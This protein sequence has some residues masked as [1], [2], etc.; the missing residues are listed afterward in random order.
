MVVHLS[1]EQSE[2]HPKEQF[3]QIHIDV[4]RN[5]TDDFNLFHDEQ[6]WHKIAKNPFKGPIV[7]GF[8]IESLIE[9]KIHHHRQKNKEEN[10]ILEKK[11]NFSNYQFSFANAIK[12]NQAITVDIKK[13]LIT[14]NE[15][16]A[17]SNRI[18][19]KADGKLCLIGFKKETQFPLFLNEANIPDIKDNLRI[20]PDHSFL[21]KKQ[22]AY[23]LKRK[24]LNVSNAKNF[25]CSSLVDQRL[26]FDEL[27]DRYNFPEI[28]PCAFISCALLEKSLLKKLDFEKFPMVYS[29]HKISID[30]HC[31]S[32]LKSND[33]LH[34]LIKKQENNTASNSKSYECYGLVTQNVILFRAIVELI[35]LAS[36][37]KKTAMSV[38]N[39]GGKL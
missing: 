37:I 8:Q 14:D 27:I 11:L 19:V 2:E 22:G 4:A 34:I 10:F 18:S 15:N 31:L 32:Q 23:F 30:R 38:I 17:M 33:V 36:I 16:P 7:L 6:R 25:L 28:F 35:P 20:Y 24:F 5:A 1:K 21:R 9:H 39:T 3:S 12:P 26:F 13:T 29:S